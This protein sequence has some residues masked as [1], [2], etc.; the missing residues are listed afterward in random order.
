MMQKPSLDFRK[1]ENGILRI[2]MLYSNHH[3]LDGDPSVVIAAAWEMIKDFVRDD[4]ERYQILG[5]LISLKV[6][7][8][9]EE[10]RCGLVGW[11]TKQQF[12]EIAWHI[13]EIL[14]DQKSKVVKLKNRFK[15]A[16]QLNAQGGL[17]E[18]SILT[19]EC[20]N[21]MIDEPWSWNKKWV[22]TK[23]I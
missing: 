9:N 15:N 12:R 1:T 21:C 10:A 4:V 17:I 11:P 18:T 2:K 8:P 5:A 22:S 23:F 14:A 6:Y 7:A 13:V 3:Y 16:P 19:I 20:N